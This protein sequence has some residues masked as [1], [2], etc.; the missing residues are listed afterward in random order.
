M[1][2]V[3][4]TEQSAL[5]DKQKFQNKTIIDLEEMLLEVS[6]ELALLREK[7]RKKE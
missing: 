5:Y 1:P 7:D 3:F 4:D 6:L 2:K